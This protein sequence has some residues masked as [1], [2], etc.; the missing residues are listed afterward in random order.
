MQT[1]NATSARL[2]S[3]GHSNLT[4]A[5]LVDLLRGAGVTAVAD[6][7]SAPYSRRLPHFNRDELKEGLRAA[8]IA[9]AFLGDQLGGRPRDRG[10]YDADG[11]VDYEAVR[12]TAAFREGLRRLLD[13]AAR[14]AVAMLCG[15]EDPLVCHRGLMI[16]PALAEA[17][18]APAHIRNG[19]RIDSNAETEERLLGLFPDL[20]AEMVQRDLFVPLPGRAAVLAEA[21]RRQARKAAFRLTDD[22]D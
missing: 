16:A 13:G 4:L 20:R 6:V 10:L 7:R 5:G 15:E 18:A 14:Y 2:F 21:Y 22:D 12:R 17:G 3:V 9:W 8:G 11:R 19:G 1:G